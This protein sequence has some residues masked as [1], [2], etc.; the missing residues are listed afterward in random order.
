MH[1][2][3]RIVFIIT[4]L[5][6]SL[7]ISLTLVNYFTAM[8]STRDQL[9]QRALPLTVDNIYNKIQKNIIEPNLIASMMAHDTFL[10]DW[11]SHEEDDI[12][13][14]TNYLEK[15]QNKYKMFTAF[16]VSDKS[17]NYY[18][19]QGLLETFNENSTNSAWYFN[20][21]KIAEPSEINIDYNTNMGSELIM[22]LNHKIYDDDYHMLGATGIG[23]K[24]SYINDMLK[25]FR[26]KHKFTVYFVDHNGNVVIS[27]K[28]IKTVPG[29]IDT[30]ELATQLSDIISK[31]SQV[32]DYR[33][34]SEAHLLSRKFIDELDLYLIVVAKVNDFTKTAKDTF[35]INIL[36]SGLITLLISIIIVLYVRRIHLKLN[37]LASNDELTNLPNRRCFHN[38]LSELL[39]YKERNNNELSIIFID[40]DDFKL[41]NDTQGHDIGDKV[42]QSLAALLKINIRKND[43]VARWGGEEFVILLVDSNL[44]QAKVIAEK[45]RLNIAN[46]VN[47]SQL[48]NNDV[49]ISS[50]VTSVTTGDDIDSILK[51][52]DNALYKAK[53]LGKNVVVLD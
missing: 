10:I 24:T 33:E 37:S 7:S 50:G 14:I 2:N 41:I 46:N 31:G 22:F 25:D 40:I 45:L 15:I 29:L 39:C 1:F 51:R 5:V 16:L 17:N 8:E 19:A 30:P 26:L 47:L 53:S 6:F 36:L 38:K 18:S 42:L 4:A 49:T 43:F 9:K 34:N 52:V 23:L 20:F 32:F 44:E 21:K 3:Y 13:Q 35:Y 27:E 48:T 28:G 11:L 12:Q